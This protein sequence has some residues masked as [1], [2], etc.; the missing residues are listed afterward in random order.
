MHLEEDAAQLDIMLCQSR[1]AV[2]KAKG[3]HIHL[4]SRLWTRR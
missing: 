3:L 2:D 4:L 1:A